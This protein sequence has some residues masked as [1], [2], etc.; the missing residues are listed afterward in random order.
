VKHS[1]DWFADELEEVRARR[2][3]LERLGDAKKKI[4]QRQGR[5]K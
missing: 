1:L 3:K 4:K 5:G 2:E